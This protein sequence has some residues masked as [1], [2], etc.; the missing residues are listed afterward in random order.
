MSLVGPPCEDMWAFDASDPL[1]R[2][3]LKLKAQNMIHPQPNMPITVST[4]MF[5]L[6]WN[7]CIRMCCKYAFGAAL[8]IT[9]LLWPISYSRILSYEIDTGFLWVILFVND[10]DFG[11]WLHHSPEPDEHFEDPQRPLLFPVGVTRRLSVPLPIVSCAISFLGLAFFLRRSSI[12]PGKC[13]MCGYNLTGNISGR[14]SEC[15]EKSSTGAEASG[16]NHAP[17]R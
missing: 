11:F 6:T 9:L 4:G 15:G 17:S 16:N 13:Q 10:G 12:P 3:S 7:Q 8:G 14:C 5:E 2:F 1:P